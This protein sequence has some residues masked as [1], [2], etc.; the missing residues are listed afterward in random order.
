M[1]FAYGP[2]WTGGHDVWGA[3]CALASSGTSPRATPAPGFD[4]W[5]CVLN[6]GDAAAA[7]TFRFQT[8]EEGEVVRDGGSVAAHSRATFKVN[9]LLGPGYQVSLSSGVHRAGGGGAAHVLRLPGTGGC[10]WDG[11]H[12]VMGAGA[13]V[14]R[15]LLRRG[16]HPGRLRGVADPAEP[17]VRRHHRQRR[18]PAGAGPGRSGEPEY[19]V[20][21]GRRFT[22]FVPARWAVEK[23]VSVRLTSASDFLAERPMYFDY[24]L[25]RRR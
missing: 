15:V 2:G 21:A 12:C 3:E 11:G 5:V 24:G 6:P 22:V 16:H 10:G 1:Y 19:T 7:L 20:G 18:L 14:A 4:E 9:D 8:Q 17:R 25:R 23:D 13:T